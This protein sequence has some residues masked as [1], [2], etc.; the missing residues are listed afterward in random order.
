M[1]SSNIECRECGSVVARRHHTGNVRFEAGVRVVL[2]RDGRVQAE[3]PCGGT[4]VIVSDS[5]RKAA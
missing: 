5:Q 4:R 2:L 3:C 1:S